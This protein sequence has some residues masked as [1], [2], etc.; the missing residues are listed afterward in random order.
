M[1][2]YLHT[3]KTK[4]LYKII[5][6]LTSTTP[7]YVDSCPRRKQ[8][9]MSS[10]TFQKPPNLLHPRFPGE[11]SRL[12]LHTWGTKAV[13]FLVIRDQLRWWCYH[14]CNEFSRDISVIFQVVCYRINIMLIFVINMF[15]IPKYESFICQNSIMYCLSATWGLEDH[16]NLISPQVLCSLQ[17]CVPLTSQDHDFVVPG[18]GWLK[19]TDQGFGMNME[20]WINRVSSNIHQTARFDSCN[21]YKMFQIWT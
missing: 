13:H 21:S 11:K 7:L 5:I 19:Q 18:R 3:R 10:P 17:W 15:I 1:D 12:V 14:C 2:S 4:A 20:S 16:E 6:K 8:K 9:G